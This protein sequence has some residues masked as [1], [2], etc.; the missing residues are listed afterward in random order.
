MDE[1]ILK[2][3]SGK[4][5][6]ITGGCGFIGSN[7]VHRLVD[8]SIEANITIFDTMDPDIHHNDIYHNTA[9]IDDIKDKIRLVRGDIRDFEHLS[10]E[11]K[12]QDI[13]IHCAAHTSH[14][15]SLKFPHLNLD[16][17]CKGSLNLL[18]AV[19]KHNDKARIIYTGS[20]S[21]IGKKKYEPIDEN[22]PEFPRD[23]YSAN[24]MLAEKYHLIYN[25]IYGLSTTVLRLS[26]I[27]GPRAA[28]HSPNF[29]F[30]NYFIGLALGNKEL[31]IYEPGDQKRTITFVDDAVNAIL[32]AVFTAESIGETIFISNQNNH[33]IKE[34]AEM[35]VKIMGRGRVKYIPWPIERKAIEVGD[36]SISNKKSSEVI[37]W[38]PQWNLEDGL[39]KTKEYYEPRLW[40]YLKVEGYNSGYNSF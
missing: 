29:G 17:N 4:N 24:K 28:I 37:K 13:I 38:T 2:K 35:I 3:F 19:R 36:I 23:I 27:Y 30:I 26:N 6:L 22:H 8:N 1:E 5:V 34:I 12:D 21:Q 32:Q 14:P 18:E 7:I 25:Y 10:E 11:V 33:S 39:R 15:L 31:T 20:S 40:K 16:V 9:N